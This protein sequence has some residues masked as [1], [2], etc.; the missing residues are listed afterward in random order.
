MV[1]IYFSET[2]DKNCRCSF[3]AI[4]KQAHRIGES[5]NL[6]AEYELYAL[7][8]KAVIYRTTIIVLVPQG[9][10]TIKALIRF[11]IVKHA[12]QLLHARSQQIISAPIL[13]NHEN[14]IPRPGSG[15]AV[16]FG[17][18]AGWQKHIFIERL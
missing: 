17:F 13:L 2:V 7:G 10:A 16:V 8:Q 1:D 18:N 12:E 14:N 11:G 9:V 4:K 15:S 6:A 3:L 5:A